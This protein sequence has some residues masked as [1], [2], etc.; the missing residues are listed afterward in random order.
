MVK[1]GGRSGRPSAILSKDLLEFLGHFLMIEGGEFLPERLE[2]RGPNLSMKDPGCRM[3]VGKGVLRFLPD[4]ERAIFGASL[5]NEDKRAVFKIF[6]PSGLELGRL[7]V[8][9]REVRGRHKT[10]IRWNGTHIGTW[11]TPEKLQEKGSFVLVLGE[12]A[13]KSFQYS[14]GEPTIRIEVWRHRETGGGQ[15]G[16]A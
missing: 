6:F 11:E 7:V 9:G 15:D 13:K 5:V 14:W 2:W 10:K 12:F 4:E 3:E 16:S 8:M 1:V